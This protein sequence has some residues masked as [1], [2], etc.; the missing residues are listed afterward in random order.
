MPVTYST[1]AKT[2]R[3][4]AVIDLIDGGVS[5]GSLRIGTSGMNV[6][7]AEFPLA[8]PCGVINNDA[9]EF[10]TPVTET[11]AIANGLAE[12]AIIV[13]SSGVTVVS[14]LTVGTAN[15]DI[16]MLDNNIS[17]LQNIDITFMVIRHI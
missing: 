11:S 14:G 5:N 12:E 8:S 13:D 3:L 4:Q 15:T 17:I 16:V 2:D 9:I 6:V 10:T 1:Q 7:L